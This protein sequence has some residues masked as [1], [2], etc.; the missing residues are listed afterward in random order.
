MGVGPGFPE[1][2]TQSRSG[3]PVPGL[4]DAAGWLRFP[5][6]RAGVCVCVCLGPSTS[7]CEGFVLVWGFCGDPRSSWIYPGF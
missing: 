2:P 3:P 4:E 5:A 1:L 7:A 6:V